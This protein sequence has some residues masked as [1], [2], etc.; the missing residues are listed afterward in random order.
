MKILLWFIIIII[1]AIGGFFA[2]IYFSKSGGRDAFS[3]IPSDAIFIIETK[4]LNK[5]WEAISNSKMWQHLGTNPYFN[6]INESAATIDSL[7]KGNKIISQLLS[8]RQLLVSAHMIS[9]YDYD[10]IFVI[11]IQKA[12]KVSFLTDILSSSLQVFDYTIN[13]RD[14]QSTEIIELTDNSTNEILYISIID[15]LLV[16]SYSGILIE[17]VILQKDENNWENNTKF[18]QVSQEISSRKL[19]NFYFNFSQ[20][21]RFMKCYLSEESELVTSISNTISYSAFNIELENEQLSFN[22]YTNLDTISSY[23]KALSKV[24]PGKMM[25]YNIIS[26]QTALYLSICYENFDD[27]YKNIVNEFSAENVE[28]YENY[29]KKIGNLE[30]FLNIN[31]QED[32]FSWLGNEIAYVKMR[33]AGNSREEDILIAIHTK[34][35]DLAKQGLTHLT[36]QI[37]KKTPVKFEIVDYQNYEI[38]YLDIK[39]FFKIFLKRL[40][41]KLEKPY[42]TFVE[43]F[44]VFSNSQSAL[45]AL[46][47]DYIKGKTLS[48][49]EDFLNF[50][51]EFDDRANV[52]IFVQM[53]K[54]YSHLYYYSKNE[55]RKGIQNNKD[56]I[57]SFSKIGFQLVSSGEMLK[58]T[59]I[60]QHDENALLAD[61]IEKLEYNATD[62]LFNTEY[63]S[64]N[65]KLTL[66]E[67]EL[68][69]EGAYKAYYPD[70][71]QKFEGTISNGELNGL[72]RTYYETGN[73]KSAV[74]YQNNKVNGNALFYY[75]NAQQTI[76]AELYYEDDVIGDIYR[77]FYENGA[78]K[79][80][81]NYDNGKLNEDAEFYYDNGALKI[82]GQYKNGEKK[83][84]WKY[85]TETGELYSRK[86]W[87]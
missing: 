18:Q 85:Y 16:C 13:K 48:H 46:I 81:L 82:E 3:V 43:D 56:L 83:G 20:L 26:S 10:F 6:D 57:L 39:G 75:N 68:S 2:Y 14:Y 52:T 60:A 49:N 73:I 66:S 58:T 8:N 27:F 35:I 11:D 25:A 74:N 1:I 61:E 4:N 54:I 9:E 50:K 17:N 71:T 72:W 79:A 78:R 30:K 37:K 44:V 86:K 28:D 22:G 76:K 55:Q 32:F 62:E 53:P 64:L 87:K 77:E 51:D 19:F 70:S 21:N 65:F 31:L 12:S 29:D 42:F 41:G 40:L 24:K 45:M 67:E 80:M 36:E 7:L 38:N 34:N 59:L 33:P 5:G 23:L 15:N 47:D 69:Y 84:K 63:E